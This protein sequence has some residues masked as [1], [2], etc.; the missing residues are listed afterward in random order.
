MLG[1]VLIIAAGTVACRS[2]DHFPYEK[3]VTLRLST[4]PVVKPR[5]L[6]IE[7]PVGRVELVGEETGEVDIA[8]EALLHA[9]A[10]RDLD[11]L[12]RACALESEMTGERYVVR[13][14]RLP[15]ELSDRGRVSYLLKVRAGKHMTL[16]VETSTGSITARAFTSDVELIASTGSLKLQDSAGAARLH[17]STGSI[18]LLN[19]WGTAE[20]TTSTGSVKARFRE[21]EGNGPM[22]FITSTGSVELELPAKINARVKG[23]TSTG[24]VECDPP[25][26]ATGQFGSKAVDGV[27]GKGTRSIEA[28]TS[29]GSVK[30]RLR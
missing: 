23:R 7:I 13:A 18:E 3:T 9:A 1:S 24:S 8:Y 25:L 15:R 27:L 26:A 17:S 2:V 21:V 30:I 19:H 11:D 22:R 16:A 29:T 5:Q 10:E 20:C 4:A 6:V 28:R 14:P 12:E